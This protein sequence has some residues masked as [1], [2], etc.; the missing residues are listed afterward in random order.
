MTATFKFMTSDELMRLQY[1][2]QNKN[3]LYEIRLEAIEDIGSDEY[4]ASSAEHLTSLYT[5]IFTTNDEIQLALPRK[6][7]ETSLYDEATVYFYSPFV[8]ANASNNERRGYLVKP[9]P[10]TLK[11][12]PVNADDELFSDPLYNDKNIRYK[13]ISV[14]FY[15]I[16]NLDC[17]L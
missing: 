12:D 15:L 17:I 11:F 14:D 1:I 4:S 9:V 6:G 5:H 10:D 7:S 3:A 13:D 8:Q 16:T 2:L